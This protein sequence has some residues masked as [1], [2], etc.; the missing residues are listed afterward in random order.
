MKNDAQCDEQKNMASAS[1]V[2]PVPQI[3]QEI[4]EHL[5]EIIRSEFRLARAEVGQDLERVRKA[6]TLLAAGAVFGL[7]AL[8]FIL[9]SLVYGL[10]STLPLWL[11][12]LIVGVGVS[13]LAA[14][15]LQIGRKKIKQASLKLDETIGSL[16][17]NVTWIKKRAR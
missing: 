13:V 6:S 11:A 1:A 17:E 3:L 10:A 12:A 4:L 15:F 8:G 16:E 2:R 7:Y 9:L 14:V 5:T